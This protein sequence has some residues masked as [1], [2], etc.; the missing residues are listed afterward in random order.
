MMVILLQFTLS[1]V[2]VINAR[3]MRNYICKNQEECSYPRVAD[4]HKET[5][6]WVDFGLTLEIG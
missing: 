1:W 4:F 6:I 3:I 2:L 5:S